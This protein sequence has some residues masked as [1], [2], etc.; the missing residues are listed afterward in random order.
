LASGEGSSDN[1]NIFSLQVFDAGNKLWGHILFLGGFMKRFIFTI[2]LLTVFSAFGYAQAYQSAFTLKAGVGISSFEN[3]D[4]TYYGLPFGASMG[5]G[6]SSK[7]EVG[8]NA[9]FTVLPFSYS[10]DQMGYTFKEEISQHNF[11]GFLKLNFIEDSRTPFVKIG[12]G[13]YFGSIELLADDESLIN[14]DLEGTF[15]FMVG[16]GFQSDNG[17]RFDLEYH[18]VS[19]KIKDSGGD[20]NGLNNFRIT[21]GYSIFNY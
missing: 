6:V 17:L 5:F 14:E 7:L 20:T 2:A 11:G 15:G 4:N 10:E 3:V 21:L 18:I 19:M 1:E 8:I 9:N 16:G 13:Y 12:A